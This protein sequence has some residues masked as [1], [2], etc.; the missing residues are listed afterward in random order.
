MGDGFPPL[1][2]VIP[3]VESADGKMVQGHLGKIQR[4]SDMGGAVRRQD[5]SF[6]LMVLHPVLTVSSM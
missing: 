6:Y 5:I 3:G 2:G 4:D 1:P